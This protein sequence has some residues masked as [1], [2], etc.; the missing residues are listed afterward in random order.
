MGGRPETSLEAL[1]QQHP[2]PTADGHSG[3]MYEASISLGVEFHVSNFLIVLLT[4]SASAKSR[5]FLL[6]LHL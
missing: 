1:S 5:L 6:H 2:S 4:N 3:I